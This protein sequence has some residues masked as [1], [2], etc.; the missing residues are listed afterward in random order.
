MH[1]ETCL[2]VQD[3]SSDTANS[4]GAEP[5]LPSSQTTLPDAPSLPRNPLLALPTPP[6]TAA[7]N[8]D[9]EMTDELSGD[10]TAS[11]QDSPLTE[12][13]VQTDKMKDAGVIVNTALRVVICLGCRCVL[14]PSAIASHV[15]KEHSLPITRTFC[16]DLLKR[17]NLDKEPT[18]PGKIIDAVYGL[19]IFH[20]FWSCNG[21]GAAFQTEGSAVRHHRD[22]EVSECQSASHSKRPAQAYSAK[23]N[24]FYFGVTI[25]PSSSNTGPD[26]ISL[27]KSSYSLPSFKTLP[28]KP[29]SFRDSGHFLAIEK[30]LEYVEGMTGEAIWRISRER[31]P[32]LRAFLKDI[33]KNYADDAVKSLGSADN[34]VRVAMGD[35]NG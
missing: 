22:S 17:Y 13:T 19:D 8:A 9:V 31:E 18:R 4:S 28:I 23:S 1:I 10:S 29:L 12:D 33:I 21:C 2:E 32:E 6:P 34:S 20:D 25:P 35:Y 3:L 16:E 7:D 30:W 14:R 15:S 26:P 24:R 27:I 11:P 5:G